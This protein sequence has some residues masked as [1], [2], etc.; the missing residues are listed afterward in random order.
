[1]VDFDRAVVEFAEGLNLD[2]VS[3]TRIESLSSEVTVEFLRY[4]LT[5]VI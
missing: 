1:M 3:V 2:M 5:K 4:I